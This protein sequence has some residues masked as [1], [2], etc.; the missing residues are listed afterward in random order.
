M[1][2]L[3]L[4]LGR[5]TGDIVIVVAASFSASL[6]DF[7]LGQ[8][9]LGNLSLLLGRATAGAL[10]VLGFFALYWLA[11]VPGAWLLLKRLQRPALAWPLFAGVALLEAAFFWLGGMLQFRKGKSGTL[12]AK[13]EED[14]R[15]WM[16]SFPLFFSEQLFIVA[17]KDGAASA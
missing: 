4:L 8:S 11:A 16:T 3:S 1:G 6:S 12:R 7:L 2:N 14:L 15:K 5:T 13:G 9:R 10:A 17:K